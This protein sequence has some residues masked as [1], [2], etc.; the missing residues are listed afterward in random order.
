LWWVGG[1]RYKYVH[2][3]GDISEGPVA[4]CVWGAGGHAGLPKI[5]KKSANIVQRGPLVG[6]A[7][8]FPSVLYL[9]GM[10]SG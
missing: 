9:M 4:G 2:C 8:Q 10:W 3:V 1:L 7:A 5:R 6:G